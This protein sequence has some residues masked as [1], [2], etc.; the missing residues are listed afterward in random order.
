MT[1]VLL[2]NG[3]NLKLLKGMNEPRLKILQVEVDSVNDRVLVLVQRISKSELVI[4]RKRSKSK[5]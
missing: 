1:S 4:P 2:I 3:N 5:K